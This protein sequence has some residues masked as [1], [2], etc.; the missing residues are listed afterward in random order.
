MLDPLWTSAI[1]TIVLV[2]VNICCIWQ[3]RQTIKEMEKARKA[4]F[5]PRIK[6][7]LHFA[8]PT[9]VN[10]KMQNVGKG[11]AVD[12]DALIKTQP[13]S[14]TRK[15]RQPL[16]APGECEFFFLPEKGEFEKL[17]NKY[18]FIVIEGSYKDIF[19]EKHVLKEKIDLKSFLSNII[20]LQKIWK[21]PEQLRCL[22]ILDKIEKILQDLVKE[23]GKIRQSKQLK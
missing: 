2:I 10:L 23:I 18:D 4:E 8:A 13:E 12:I 11:A 20:G 19:G 14:G 6:A 1:A 3:N 9:F 21:E 7:T 17:A 16:M 15:W 22:K 5:L